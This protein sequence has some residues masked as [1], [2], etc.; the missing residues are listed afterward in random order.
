MGWRMTLR[1]LRS[2]LVLSQVTYKHQ[3]ANCQVYVNF[4]CVPNFTVCKYVE[5]K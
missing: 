4:D 2:L 1:G 5:Q 3:Q